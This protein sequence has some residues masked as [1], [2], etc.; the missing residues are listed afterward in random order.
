[1]I[2]F[3][4]KKRRKIEGIVEMFFLLNV[5]ILFL[6]LVFDMYGINP[7]IDQSKRHNPT[8][9]KRVKCHDRLVEIQM[10]QR[11]NR[12]EYNK[13][14]SRILGVKVVGFNVA[15]LTQSVDF[16]CTG[17]ISK[18]KHKRDHKREPKGISDCLS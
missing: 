13:N 3:I 10:N 12:I 18:I 11:K 4:T 16:L 8:V 6:H 15:L 5:I 9:M 2:H 1:M 14:S 7:E 17:N